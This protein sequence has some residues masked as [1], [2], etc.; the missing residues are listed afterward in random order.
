MINS[1]LYTSNTDEWETPK[2]FFDK[3]DTEFHFTL[4]VAASNDNHKCIH[5]YTKD[6]DGLTQ[7]WWGNVWCNPPYGRE[8]ERWVLKACLSIDNA[9]VIVM[10]LPTRT[11]THWFHRHV[12]NIAELRFIEGRL[13]FSNSKNSAPFPSM[14][15]I[16]KPHA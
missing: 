6:N 2:A 15:A 12:Y 1:S 8:I 5:W 11:D 3:L 4:D 16:Y 9:N 7:S 10:L 14:L 13:H